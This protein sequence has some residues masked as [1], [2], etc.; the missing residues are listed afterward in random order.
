MN[1][2]YVYWMTEYISFV[3]IIYIMLNYK[4]TFKEKLPIL[5]VNKKSLLTN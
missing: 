2:L 4:N 1:I 3:N 5:R